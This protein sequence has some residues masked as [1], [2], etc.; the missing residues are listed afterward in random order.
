M[1]SLHCLVVSIQHSRMTFLI[2]YMLNQVDAS[3]QRME[4]LPFVSYPPLQV[5]I[6]VSK[7]G[8]DIQFEPEP[9]RTE[10][11]L[12]VQVHWMSW[13]RPTVWFRVQQMWDFAEPLR[14]HLNTL[15]SPQNH[16]STQCGM[17]VPGVAWAAWCCT[18]CGRWSWF[19]GSWGEHNRV[20]TNR[21]GDWH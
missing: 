1:W 3:L 15:F 14:M 4:I 6:V 5:S 10:P 20:T 2:L 19:Q 17:G 12:L 9:D 18:E 11:L 13:T 7:S 21:C 16:F 8:S